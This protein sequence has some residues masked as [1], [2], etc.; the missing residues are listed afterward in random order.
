[1]D[2][3]FK[4]L[5]VRC[6]IFMVMEIGVGMFWVVM[7]CGVAVENKRFGGPCCLHFQIEVNGDGKKGHICRPGVEPG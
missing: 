6:E 4:I 3:T 5:D 1:M 2:C 7:M